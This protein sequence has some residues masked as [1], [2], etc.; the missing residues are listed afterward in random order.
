M[1][2]S[3]KLKGLYRVKVTHPQI[4]RF[5]HFGQVETYDQDTKDSFAKGLLIIEDA[6][7]GNPTKYPVTKEAMITTYPER[8]PIPF[9]VVNVPFGNFEE[10]DEYQKYVDTQFEMAQT[11]SKA[12][13]KG[14]HKGKLFKTN[15][16]D[17]YAWYVITKVNKAT[18]DIEWRAF[19]PDR[20][21]DQILGWGGR[22]PKHVV[23][24]PIGFEEAMSKF[25][26]GKE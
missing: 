9:E 22:F 23:E 1:S 24:R 4:K 16:A 2:K 10:K 8:T 5:S 18:V 26:A 17:G 19:C 21:H 7:T 13:P 6:V 3:L 20:W 12:L 25:F 11:L 14:V 15:V